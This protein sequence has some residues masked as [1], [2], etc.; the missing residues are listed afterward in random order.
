MATT[1]SARALLVTPWE[2]A[3]LS[4]ASVFEEEQ[5]SMALPTLSSTLRQ[6]PKALVQFFFAAV[7]FVLRSEMSQAVPLIFVEAVA[8]LSAVQS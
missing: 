6:A 2:M 3:A 8:R 1:W 4:E 5:A 7:N